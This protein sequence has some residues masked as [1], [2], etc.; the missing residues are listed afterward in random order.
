LILGRFKMKFG[1]EGGEREE[2]IVSRGIALHLGIGH[3]N[4]GRQ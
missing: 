4:D 3:E 1:R 2:T